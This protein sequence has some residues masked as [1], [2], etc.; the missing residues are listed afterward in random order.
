MFHWTIIA[1]AK[2]FPSHQIIAC[3]W[4]LFMLVRIVACLVRCDMHTYCC[5]CCNS[6]RHSMLRTD[7]PQTTRL[8]GGFN[9]S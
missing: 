1:H 8:G 2:Y 3:L 6:Y 4:K 5:I 7:V 9:Y